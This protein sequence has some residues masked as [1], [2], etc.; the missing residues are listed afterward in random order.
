MWLAVH[1]VG[2]VRG[3]PEPLLRLCELLDERAVLRGRVMATNE[4][5][6]RVGLRALDS[7]IDDALVRLGIR[8]V[9]PM[10]AQREAAD[11]WMS[12]LARWVEL[13][14]GTLH[15]LSDEEWE[16]RHDGE[17]VVLIERNEP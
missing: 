9:L 1:Q 17:N 16:R 6:D 15:R 14:D 4:W 2:E 7:Q 12:E 8:T 5:R 3:N 11:D 13:G 10:H